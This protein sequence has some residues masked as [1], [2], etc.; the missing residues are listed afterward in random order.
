LTDLARTARH[1]SKKGLCDHVV[2]HAFDKMLNATL[3]NRCFAIDVPHDRGT[4]FCCH[5][6]A[7][8]EDNSVQVLLVTVACTFVAASIAA[9]KRDPQSQRKAF[10]SIVVWSL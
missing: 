9:Q 3:V 7:A 4:V 10:F 6:A 8:L 1:A 5:V 2:R